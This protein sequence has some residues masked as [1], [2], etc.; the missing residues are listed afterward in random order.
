MNNHEFR[1]TIHTLFNITSTEKR[2]L[3]AA[4]KFEL[5]HAQTESMIE[6]FETIVNKY[7]ILCTACAHVYKNLAKKHEI[8]H[9]RLTAFNIVGTG[10]LAW[11]KFLVSGSSKE[12][13]KEALNMVS[14]SGFIQT[15]QSHNIQRY[16][17]VLKGI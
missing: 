9:H 17:A 14:N 6:K 8:T 13:Q 10:Y 2:E 15:F 11:C 12:M 4:V 7:S 1:Q 5:N 3:L 16:N